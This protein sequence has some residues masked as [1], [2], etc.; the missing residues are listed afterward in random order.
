MGRLVTKGTCVK[1]YEAEIMEI[2]ITFHKEGFDSK[3]I[4]ESVQQQCERFMLDLTEIGIK[5]EQVQIEDEG[6]TKKYGESGN[7][8]ERYITIR[9]KID[10]RLGTYICSLIKKY[11]GEIR[12]RIQYD[13]DENADRIQEL[14]KHAVEDSRR[15][16]D[17]IAGSLGKRV[18]DVESVN[19]PEYLQKVYYKRGSDDIEPEIPDFFNS[20]TPLSDR[21]AL[22][23]VELEKEVTV[24]W[25]MGD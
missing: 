11:S 15:Q 1:E 20:D 3:M 9:S 8:A 22:P 17:I 24:A 25:I 18:I 16:A 4:L 14:L 10:V 12:Y 6:I 21:A 5:P 2:T 13:L 7:V 23:T 19:D